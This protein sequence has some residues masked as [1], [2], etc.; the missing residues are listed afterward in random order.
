MFSQQNVSANICTYDDVLSI[1]CASRVHA[2]G[3]CSFTFDT[4]V[5]LSLCLIKHRAMKM[6]GGVEA[7]IH[8]FI[9]SGTEVSN[10]LHDSV[11][12]SWGERATGTQWIGD[13]V[14]FRANVN[15]VKNS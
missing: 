9:T 1:P 5:K 13:W 14:G 2:V 15:A 7:K 6:Y 12:L 11:A 4:K 8:A 10:K 3:Y